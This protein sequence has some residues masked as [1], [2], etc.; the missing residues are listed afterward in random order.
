M[1]RFCRTLAQLRASAGFKTAYSFYHSNG[2]RRV[3]PFTYAYYAKIERGDAL[4]RA[5]WLAVLLRHMRVY[6][7][8]QHSEVVRAYLRELTDD[9]DAFEQ[10][11]APL[12]ASPEESAQQRAM[13][14]MR[15]RTSRHLTPRELQTI[16]SSIEAAKCQ[17]LLINTRD[18]LHVERI[19]EL[20]KHPAAKCL[21]ALKELARHGLV[22]AHPGGRFSNFDAR[23]HPT[24]PADARSRETVKKIMRILREVGKTEHE[25]V[26][27]FRLDRPALDAVAA[28]LKAAFDLASGLSRWDAGDEPGAP[29]YVLEAR[30][31]RVFEY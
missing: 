26:D 16:A 27:T 31:L 23:V 14:S 5:S 13:R 29:I 15:A 22:R 7:R 12:L 30:A 10:L 11:F 2:G 3:F 21:I 20:I 9:A 4:P 1:T 19:A 17:I 24:V 28:Q 25:C 18:P 8:P 6:G